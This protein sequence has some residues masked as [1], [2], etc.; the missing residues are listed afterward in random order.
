MKIQ[1]FDFWTSPLLFLSNISEIKGSF[2][3]DMEIERHHDDQIGNLTIAKCSKSKSFMESQFLYSISLLDL[4]RKP[5]VDHS[6]SFGVYKALNS[7]QYTWS[8]YVPD[9]RTRNFI[10]IILTLILKFSEFKWF[11]SN[12]IKHYLFS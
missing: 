12:S 7:I 6:L 9:G 3:R 10:R 8:K 1:D 11:S 5:Q 2:F 4:S